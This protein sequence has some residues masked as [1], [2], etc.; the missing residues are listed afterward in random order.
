MTSP[1]FVRS[2]NEMLGVCALAGELAGCA[3]ETL[4]AGV[5]KFAL[6]FAALR[7]PGRGVLETRLSS[8]GTVSILPPVF[9]VICIHIK[10]IASDIPACPRCCTYSPLLRALCRLVPSLS[11]QNLLQVLFEVSRSLQVQLR[12]GTHFHAVALPFVAQL[13]DGEL[14]NA[15]D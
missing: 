14:V 12:F 2:A 10:R 4:E 3:F 5:A 6:R 9:H 1:G 11:L 8:L 7:A 15:Q 13:L